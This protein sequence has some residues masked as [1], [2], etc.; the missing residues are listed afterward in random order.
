M[1]LS[2]DST[3][4]G[5]TMRLITAIL[6]ALSLLT[7]CSETSDNR[8]LDSS[9][10]FGLKQ[11]LVT[12]GRTPIDYVVGK[13]VDHDVVFIG[14]H[15]CI[16]HDPILVQYLI[17]ALYANGISTLGFEFANRDDQ[18]LVDS[19]LNS[20]EWDEALAR[21][22]QINQFSAWPYREYLDIY[23][24]AWE[25]NRS[26]PEDARPFR[27]LGLNCDV[28]W[29]PIQTRADRDNDDKK[30]LVW[31]GCTEKD[32]ADVILEAVEDGNK[33]LVYCGIHHAFTGYLQP[34]V[35]GSGEFIRFEDCRTGT[36]VKNA[37]GDR[38][39]TIFL[40]SP[41]DDLDNGYNGSYV[42]PVNGAVDEVMASLGEEA[43][44]VGFD[45]TD[46]PFAT[47]KARNTVYAAGYDD[48]TLGAFCD[49]YIWTKPFEEY[50]TVTFV[51]G[52]YTDDNIELARIK[53]P[54]PSFRNAS[55][56]RFDNSLRG[57]LQK[58]LNR[59]RELK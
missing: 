24:A 27:I 31:K 13:F 43:A 39:M 25:L 36:Y 37:L 30:K 26:L 45:I 55:V 38:C 23:E 22:I 16:R 20:A 49:G 3:Y 59:F 11:Y 8:K 29:S 47:L 9:K 7:G 5:S 46:S 1:S 40:H 4:K 15:H 53:T 19:L 58:T 51:D 12:N 10:L 34:I 6:I 33:V 57:D 56:E 42:K 48:F 44:P 32:W 50:E 21:H 14:E 2:H 41:W 54:A 28:D 35:N 17:P 52:F 18:P